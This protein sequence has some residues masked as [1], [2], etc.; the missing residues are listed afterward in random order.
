MTSC[1][2]IIIHICHS[3][4]CCD[5]NNNFID[6]VEGVCCTISE[7]PSWQSGTVWSGL[8]LMSQYNLQAS[9]S[10]SRVRFLFSS[11]HYPLSLSDFQKQTFKLKKAKKI[12]E[13]LKFIIILFFTISLHYGSGWRYYYD[14]SRLDSVHLSNLQIR[15]R[16]SGSNTTQNFIICLF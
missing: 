15:K 5:L 10:V 1:N 12:S 3:L 7:L 6:R 4:F 16:K 2:L 11:F 9:V 14:Y 8:D 13:V